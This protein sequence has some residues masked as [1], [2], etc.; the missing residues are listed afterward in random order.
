MS[1]NINTTLETTQFSTNLAMR[2]QQHGSKLRGRVQEGFHTGKMASPVQYIG[3]VKARRV[4]GRFNPIGRVDAEFTRRWVFPL[5]YDLPQMI[6]SFDLLKTIVNPQ[7]QYV[8]NAAAAVR[9]EW[10]DQIITAAT[11]T[12]YLGEDA[13]GLTTEAFDT[14]NFRIADNFEASA[15]NGLTVAKL[16]EAK[17]IL[18][19]YE[20]DI[21]SEALTLVIGSKQESDLLKQTQIVS[22]EFNDTPVLKDGRL[23]RFLG[24]DI[25]V[26]ERLPTYTTTTRGVLAFVKSALYLGVWK[27]TQN[28]ASQ[29]KDLSGLPWQL[30]TCF[31]TGAT[32]LE[33][34]KLIQIACKDAT[35]AAITP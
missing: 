11:A 5:D 33:P 23:V 12:A 17:R 26:M 6:D 8:T 4:E 30:Y 2:L 13:G 1:A 18:R 22:K 28:D 3:P 16:I 24:F 34:G 25:V 7:S 20:N 32:R 15:A 35:G 29:R 31:S 10:D 21:D 19:H 9:R 27:D 14:T